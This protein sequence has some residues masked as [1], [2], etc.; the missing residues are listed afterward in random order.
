MMIYYI[1]NCCNKGKEVRSR[2]HRDRDV[3]LSWPHYVTLIHTDINFRA[4]E[5]VA[6][7]N[8]EPPQSAVQGKFQ[9][10][11]HARMWTQCTPQKLDI[12][13]AVSSSYLNNLAS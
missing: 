8:S 5:S 9:Y 1:A 4:T 10:F 3:K 2:F 7:P 12:V 6:K 13:A 11:S